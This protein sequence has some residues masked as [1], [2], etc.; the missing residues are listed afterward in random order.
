MLLLLVL[1]PAVSVS[2]STILAVSAATSA[3]AV[4][5]VLRLDDTL[6][7]SPFFANSRSMLKGLVLFFHSRAII[8]MGL[9]VVH[10]RNVV[11]LWLW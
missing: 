11:F 10:I 6:H 1:V 7:E 8:F 9:V 2:L 5:D 3:T 4:H